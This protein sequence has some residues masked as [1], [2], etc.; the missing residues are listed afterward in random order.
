[1]KKTIM[2]GENAVPMEATA[3][4]PILYEELFPDRDLID[5]TLTASNTLNS[6]AGG[7]TSYNFVLRIAYV[8]AKEADPTIGSFKDWLKQ[9]GMMDIFNVLNEITDM[10][11]T[12][13]EPTARPKKK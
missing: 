8:M 12:S 13:A 9:F 10:W 6:D 1:M 7:K 5:E 2:I 3:F 11:N 4:T